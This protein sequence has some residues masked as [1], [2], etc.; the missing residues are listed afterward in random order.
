MPFYRVPVTS[1]VIGK[2]P[3]EP[4]HLAAV[5]F[6]L[7]PHKYQLDYKHW[8]G[9]KDHCTQSPVVSAAHITPPWLGYVWAGA[10]AAS[11]CPGAFRTDLTECVTDCTYD[12]GNI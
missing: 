10:L 9:E 6:K 1:T 12:V 7:S 3:L 8:R 4:C 2:A 5:V 11:E